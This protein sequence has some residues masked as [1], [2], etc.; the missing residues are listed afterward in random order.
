MPFANWLWD[1]I[2]KRAGN[3]NRNAGAELTLAIPT[4]SKEGL[5]LLLRLCS[6]WGAVVYVMKNG[7]ISENLWKKPVV[8]VIEDT[9]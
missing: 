8:N 5:D 2:G 1:E 3:L 4:L 6:F 9:H 7:T